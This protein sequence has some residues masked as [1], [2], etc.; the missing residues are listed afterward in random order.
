M[1]DFRW[2]YSNHFF[3]QFSYNMKRYAFGSEQMNMC[4]PCALFYLMLTP[5][6]IKCK[7][8]SMFLTRTL[9]YSFPA[10]T[11]STFEHQT[12]GKLTFMN[13]TQNIALAYG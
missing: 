11:Q 9:Q 5:K 1:F 3:L 13:R 10:S 12:T 7:K 4:I 2:F 6:S 8:C